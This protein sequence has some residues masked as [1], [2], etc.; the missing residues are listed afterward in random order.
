MAT[1]S[2]TKKSGTSN[3]NSFTFAALVLLIIIGTLA[4]LGASRRLSQT[5]IQTSTEAYSTDVV[6]AVL[7]GPPPKG[8]ECH[9]LKKILQVDEDD[10]ARLRKQVNCTGPTPPDW[11]GDDLCSIIGRRERQVTA[12]KKLIGAICKNCYNIE[13]GDKPPR[14]VGPISPNPE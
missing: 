3:K 14:Y 1:Q 12:S 13:I 8:G 11:T 2:R 10:I 7:T 4:V 6:D 9:G 5:T